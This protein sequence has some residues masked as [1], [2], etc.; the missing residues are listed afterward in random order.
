[1]KRRAIRTLS[2]VFLAVLLAAPVSAAVYS[3]DGSAR[4]EA[5]TAES[6]QALV[7]SLPENLRELASSLSPADPTAAADA[8]KERTGFSWWIGQIGGTLKDTLA[9]IFP[10]LAPLLSV[11]ILSAIDHKKIFNTHAKHGGKHK[12]VIYSRKRSSLLPFVDSLRSSKAEYALKFSHRYA[13]FLPDC[14]DPRTGPDHVNHRYL[15]PLHWF[16]SLLY[17]QQFADFPLLP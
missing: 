3:Y 6:W 9:S 13:A 8:I 10:S 16:H 15:Y 14:V 7:D 17:C 12:K 1:M 11:L 4:S 2:A 5:R